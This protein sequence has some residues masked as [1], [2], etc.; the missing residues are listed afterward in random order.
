MK[1][2][3]IYTRLGSCPSAGYLLLSRCAGEHWTLL[4]LLP[5]P[6]AIHRNFPQDSRA[7]PRQAPCSPP[8]QTHRPDAA[9]LAPGDTGT[10]I[11]TEPE[12]RAQC[13]DAGLPGTLLRRSPAALR[14][15]CPVLSR[16]SVPCHCQAGKA[17]TSPLFSAAF[18]GGQPST[19]PAEQST[20]GA[21]FQRCP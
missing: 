2:Y 1:Q 18:P 21:A 7:P 11:P 15:H 6:R 14:L 19:V 10:G 20:R 13:R 8:M 9:R 3:W 16:V 12:A 17:T 5:F 4:P